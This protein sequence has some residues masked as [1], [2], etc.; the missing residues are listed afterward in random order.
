MKAVTCTDVDDV[1]ANL[2][3]WDDVLAYLVGCIGM[4]ECD[5][6]YLRRLLTC[7][8]ITE[9]NARGIY[10]GQTIST[11]NNPSFVAFCTTDEVLF[12]DGNDY[13]DVVIF[14]TN[15]IKLTLSS[16]ISTTNHIHA[17]HISGGSIIKLLQCGDSSPLSIDYLRV[18]GCKSFISRVEATKDIYIGEVNKI[19]GGFLGDPVC[20]DTTATPCTD[21]V[22]SLSTQNITMSSIDLVYVPPAGSI[23]LIVQYRKLNEPV[24]L[25]VNSDSQGHFTAT[26]FTFTNLDRD[27]YYDFR[28]KSIC[29]GGYP[30]A[31]VTIQDKTHR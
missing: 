21:E 29:T 13:E 20:L 5:L 9:L 16:S 7:G 11:I 31:G 2:N 27:T 8:D 12:D 25:E 6:E 18:A 14:A 22:T 23:K 26:G 10:F 3:G 30:S 19:S 17:L 15:L 28:V 1:D 24:W 4:F